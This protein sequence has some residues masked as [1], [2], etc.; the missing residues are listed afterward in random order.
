MAEALAAAEIALPMLLEI[1]REL[2]T[3]D[4]ARADHARKRL[5]ALKATFVAH[6]LRLVV[7]QA[8]R[9]RNMGVAFLDLIQEGNLGL[10]RAVEKFDHSRGFKFSTYAVWW[11]EQALIRA[12]QNQSRTVRV[13]SHIYEL[14]IGQRRIERELRQRL[15]RV[16]TRDELAAAL[17][18]EPEVLDRVRASAIPNASLSA[19]VPGTDGMVFED[20]LADEEATDP[21][22]AE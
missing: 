1:H 10:V 22:E 3:T 8:K 4:A 9:F 15:G 18:I 5:E 16:P 6:N 21:L 17:E 12:I 7:T 19:P 20:L 2:S 14:Q 11:I 13:P